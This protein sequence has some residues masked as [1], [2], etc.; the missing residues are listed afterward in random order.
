MNRGDETTLYETNVAV[1]KRL[2][3]ALE[4][5]DRKPRVVFASSTQR[6]RPTAYG[7]SKKES[8]RLLRGWAEKN[9]GD[10]TILVIPNV[11][12]PGC[13][14]FYNSVVAT[15]CHQLAHG[16][17]P[18]VIDDQKIEFV[19]VNDLVDAIVESVNSARSGLNEIRIDKTTHLTVSKL[20]A[21]L[22]AIHR[23]YF[24]DNVV[25]DL[26]DPLEARLYSTFL[27]HVDLDDHRH[28]PRVHRDA[29]FAGLRGRR[30]RRTPTIDRLDHLGHALELDR[31]RR[32][33]PRPHEHGG[34]RE[35]RPRSLQPSDC[36]R[37][38]RGIRCV[39]FDRS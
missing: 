18:V 8:E 27:S 12:G 5:T 37:A 28:R 13:R 14:P 6:D 21:K 35:P 7:R 31:H 38:D 4:A 17:Q 30:R 20:L 9:K 33:W 2:I 25:P 23:S 39:Q 3:D 19:W 16:Q 1:A 34:P 24:D 32:Q 22:T 11:Y 15:F 36:D 10:L 29:R 26:S